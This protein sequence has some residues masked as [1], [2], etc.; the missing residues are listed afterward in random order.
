MA[1]IEEPSPIDRF[2]DIAKR[3]GISNGTSIV[4]IE[5]P[6]SGATERAV[7]ISCTAAVVCV[8]AAIFLGSAVVY[9]ARVVDDH[10]HQLNAIYMM[11][12]SLREAVEKDKPE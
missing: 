12:P 11:A 10:R 6:K 2:A 7:W 4:K 3:L 5:L 1:D 9:L 8:M